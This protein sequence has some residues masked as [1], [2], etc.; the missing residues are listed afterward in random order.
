MEPYAT[1]VGSMEVSRNVS[2]RASSLIASNSPSI[3]DIRRTSAKFNSTIEE[4]AHVQEPKLQSKRRSVSEPVSPRRSLGDIKIPTNR[5]RDGSMTCF[6]KLPSRSC[7]SDWLTP[8]GLF[9]EFGM[10]QQREMMPDLYARGVDAH[11]GINVSRPLE[12]L[13][14]SPRQTPVP[15]TDPP[16]RESMVQWPGKLDE[17]PEKLSRKTGR[18]IGASSHRRKSSFKSPGVWAS[19][20]NHGLLDKLRRYSF[21]PLLDQTSESSRKV[22]PLPRAWDELPL[23]E[24]GG[25]RYSSQALLQGLLDGKP[26]SNKSSRKS[27]MSGARRQRK[28]T[29]SSATQKRHSAEPGRMSCSEDQTP[30]ICTD[31][32]LTPFSGS[33]TAWFE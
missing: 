12:I 4:S 27:S 22:L 9:N 28:K 19:S 16:F 13:E 32:Q 8:L 14:E 25:R 30:H 1:V 26:A 2:T 18:A 15:P 6:P 23:R 21:M 20:T 7:T 3:C 11:C 24:E 33:E 17:K 10:P 31:E 29:G 5:C